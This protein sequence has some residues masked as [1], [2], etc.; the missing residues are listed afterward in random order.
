MKILTATFSIPIQ[1]NQLN[2]WRGAL[3]EYAGWSDDQFHNHQG[4]KNQYHY[5]YPTIAYRSHEGQAGLFA[6]GE[7]VVSI[8]DMLLRS[9]KDI[10]IGNRYM[11]LH[12]QDF[13]INNYE[14]SMS[15]APKQYY[16]KNWLALNADN[17]KKWQVLPSLGE[18]VAM[19]EQILSSNIVSFAKGVAWQLPV[20]VEAKL[21]QLQHTHKIISHRTEL[22]A[23]DVVFAANI[24]LPEGLGLGKSCSLG[25][26][27]VSVNHKSL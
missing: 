15:E 11:P 9:S 3:A 6:L 16:L 14:P 24:D 1:P 25:F 18:R 4:E 26:G 13:R 2:Q 20:R 27:V 10:R 23:F 19:L 12:I 17:Y 7:G 5:R 22:I 21:V 8:Q